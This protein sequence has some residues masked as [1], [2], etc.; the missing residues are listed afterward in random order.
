MGAAFVIAIIIGIVYVGYLSIKRNNETKD[1]MVLKDCF[2]FEQHGLGSILTVNQ[3]STLGANNISLVP[4][5]E[6]FTKDVP[7]RIVYTGATVGGITTGGF[8][9]QKGGTAYSYGEK[10]GKDLLYYKY[11]DV[12]NDQPYA[13]AIS[14]LQLTDELLEEARE[15]PVMKKLIV[16]DSQLEVLHRLFFNSKLKN[17]IS[18]LSIDEETAKEVKSWLGEEKALPTSGILE[19]FYNASGCYC[20]FTDAGIICKN[21]VKHRFYPY[22]SID[23]IGFSLGSLDIA[24]KINGKKTAFIYAVADND[25]KIHIERLIEFAKTKISSSPRVEAYEIMQDSAHK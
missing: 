24:G 25:Q 18:L 23:K 19:E 9:I 3:K 1:Q 22:G 17:L 7:D 11:A 8:H 13:C 12:V 15:H 14:F 4:C 20:A 6:I 16:S 21:S 5:Y 10:T 2:V